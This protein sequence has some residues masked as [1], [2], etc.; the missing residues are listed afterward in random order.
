[1]QFWNFRRMAAG[2]VYTQGWTLNDIDWAK[3]DAAEV[4]PWLL[5]MVKASAL[6]ELNAP[7]YVD[8]LKRVFCDA[9]PEKQAAIEHWGREESQHGRALGRWAELADSSFKLDKAFARFRKNYRPAHFASDETL[10]V[11][12][13]RRGEMIARCVVE[14]GT[15]SHYSAIRDATTEP[16]LKEIAARIA[17]D[18]YRHYRFFF[19]TLHAER[20]P[21]LPFWRKLLIAARRVTESD[22]D[23]LSYAYYCANVL[24]RDEIE[25]PYH[26]KTYAH[27]AFSASTRAY[28]FSHIRKL[29][30]MVGNAI[31]AHP[32]SRLI[33]FAAGL[34][35]VMLRL[36]AGLWNERRQSTASA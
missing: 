2:T 8:Y 18:E 15:S 36:R 6:V 4:E 23:E 9:G 32:R 1:M 25:R 7:D 28:R 17:A 27:K 10:S 20:E 33:R 22:D 11:R 19:D 30:Q 16:V 29:T 13:S 21:D 12:G 14:S 3:F 35:W 26:R 31:G 24:E 34:T 5:A